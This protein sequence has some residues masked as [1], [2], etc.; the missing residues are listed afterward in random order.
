MFATGSRS[1]T[2]RPYQSVTVDPLPVAHSGQPAL[3][4]A[5]LASEQSPLF[6]SRFPRFVPNRETCFE[7]H[8]F[9]HLKT[10]GNVSPI[11]GQPRE[12]TEKAAVSS[13]LKA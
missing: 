2:N 11:L 13:T 3:E 8:V 10:Q 5:L 4:P 9:L 7:K 1:S 12:L 6:S